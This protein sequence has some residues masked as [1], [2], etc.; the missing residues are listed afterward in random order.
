MKRITIP[1]K[2]LLGTALV[3]GIG[4]LGVIA[5]ADIIDPLTSAFLPNDQIQGIVRGGHQNLAGALSQLGNGVT[6]QVGSCATPA[7]SATTCT[8]QLTTAYNATPECFAQDQGTLFLGAKAVNVAASKTVTVTAASST[9]GE[10]FDVVCH[11]VTN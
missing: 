6:Y 9:A 11:A 1:R 8:F 3:I 5:K 7:G 10:V 2:L 4:G